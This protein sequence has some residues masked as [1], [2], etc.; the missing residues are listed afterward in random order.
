MKKIFIILLSV[1][2]LYGNLFAQSPYKISLTTD[3]SLLAGGVGAL[4]IGVYSENSISP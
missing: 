1:L 2:V 3:L 4:G